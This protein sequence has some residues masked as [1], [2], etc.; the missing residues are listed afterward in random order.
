MNSSLFYLSVQVDFIGVSI[1]ASPAIVASIV[2]FGE[3]EQK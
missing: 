1:V 2:A 3:I